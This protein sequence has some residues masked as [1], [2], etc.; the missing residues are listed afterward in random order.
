MTPGDIV[1]VPFPHVED[2]RLQ[3]RP[4]LIVATEL[5]GPLDLCWALM[6][7]AAINPAWPEDVLIG[8]D[9]ATGLPAP[10]RVRTGKIATLAATS[11]TLVGRLSDRDWRAV[12]G[13]LARLLRMAAR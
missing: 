3:S 6:I 1:W 12:Q 9:E 13:K 8:D 4:A 2:N 5:A 7:T 10:S 11:T